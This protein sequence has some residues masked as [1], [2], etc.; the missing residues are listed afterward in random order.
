[1]FILFVNQN[2]HHNLHTYIDKCAQMSFTY[3]ITFLGHTSVYS[4]NIL[5]IKHPATCDERNTRTIRSMLY[6]CVCVCQSTHTHKHAT[7][8]LPHYIGCI[9]SNPNIII[10][11]PVNRCCVRFGVHH[12]VVH[13][14]LCRTRAHA[15]LNCYMNICANC[16]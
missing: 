10:N 14:G 1:M 5:L 6:A 15:R 13:F 3:N 7:V 8:N 4:V 9:Q 12:A 11:Y 2:C 16:V